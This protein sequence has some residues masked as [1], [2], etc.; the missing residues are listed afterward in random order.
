VSV[1]QKLV[2]PQLSCVRS[3]NAPGCDPNYFPGG[4]VRST[5]AFTPQLAGWRQVG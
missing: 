3:N 1:A 2:D 4:Y 5:L